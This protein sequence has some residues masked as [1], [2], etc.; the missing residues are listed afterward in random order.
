MNRKAIPL[1]VILIFLLLP[2]PSS[3]PLALSPRGILVRP[4]KNIQTEEDIDTL[5]SLC[6][7]YQTSYIFLMVKQD[8]GAESG[9][10][11][12]NSSKVPRISDFDILS[13]TLEK[14]HR[15]NIK[16]YAWI[17]L[18]YDKWAAEAGLSIEGNWISPLQSA[19]YYAAIVG[20]IAP[21][22]VD[23]ILFDYL[24]FSD[25]LAASEQLKQNFGQKFGY[26]MN[27]VE[28]SLEKERNTQLWNQWITY[29]EEIL[30][31]FLETIMPKTMP[32]GIT[33]TSD[34]LKRNS[35]SGPLAHVNFV[36]LQVEGDP[37]SMINTVTLSTEAEI[38]VTLPNDY[39]SQV[40]QLMSESSYTELLIFNSDIWNESAFKR[41]S[42]AEV[43]FTDV[44]MTTLP[45]IDFFNKK[46]D[47]KTWR[48]YEVNTVVF[49][50]GHVFWTYFKY[51][52]YR[53]K[54]SLYTEK[55]GRDY[56][57]EVIS[58][59]KEAGL[60][61]VLSLNIQSEE[62]VTK[63]KD[64]ASI[65]YQWG[66]MR[67]RICLS[68]LNG[69]LY[70]SEFFEMARYLADY[71]EAEA[72]LITSISYLEDC[73]CTDCLKSYTDFMAERGITVEDWPRSDGEIDIYHQTVREWKTAQITHFLGDLREHLRDSNKEL[74][75]E[76]PVSANIEYMSSEYGLY[77]PE[78]EPIVDRVVLVNIDMKNPPRIGN[79]VKS[80]P[81]S[82]YVLN[83]FIEAGK[84]PARTNLEDSLKIAYENGISSV[85]MYP[86]S[87]VTESLWS[88]LYITYVYRLASTDTGLMEIYKMGD[89]GSVISAYF[90]LKEERKLE[91]R[92]T[93]ERAR[94]NIQEAEKSYYKVLATLGEARRVDL[95]VAAFEVEIQK[96]LNLLSDAKNLFIEG[97]YE[98]AEEKGKTTIIEF[99]TLDVRID[100][101]VRQEEIKR[102]SSGVLI[103]V[104]FLLI[105]MYVRF[106]M[107]R[108][109]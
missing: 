26:N 97:D 7:K 51:L 58:E 33:I 103:V 81:G 36:A 29:R 53:E 69:E 15:K 82:G 68:E 17:P 96:N 105:M 37:T 30:S 94:Q 6:E 47:M 1:L 20:E 41:I 98:S 44:R 22:K 88:A 49:P 42:K 45:F 76:V 2:H 104:V 90:L 9:L 25:D 28:L 106:T 99:S 107:G 78:V 52:P 62:Y 70:R 73:F 43:P 87:S 102:V 18:L 100:N 12:Y 5:I 56:V 60:Y 71:Y 23:G 34:D 38:Y 46:Y 19:P 66:V 10:V 79:V 109:R 85:G 59:A 50:A 57:E 80:L 21:Y 54:W 11:Y 91:E 67:N 48:I 16:V 27:S 14:A 39:V 64:A 95:N 31:Q 32:V 8:T 84:L 86:S 77:L 55:Y 13:R 35:E 24:R 101:M 63:Y 61:T 72:V 108:K 74:W 89:Y 92:Q 4:E 83:F 93:R 3:S 40:R 75:V 65:T